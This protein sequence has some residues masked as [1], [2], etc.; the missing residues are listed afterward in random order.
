MLFRSSSLP[1]EDL[2]LFQVSFDTLFSLQA[3][4]LQL[5]IL[6]LLKGTKLRSQRE[7]YHFVFQGNAPYD[8]RASAWLKEEEMQRIHACAEAVEKF[9]NSAACRSVITAIL[10]LHW[11][12]SA[13][14]LFMDRTYQRCSK[15]EWSVLQQIHVWL[16]A[17]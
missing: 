4:E 15:N 3:S 5:G 8:V 16:K 14:A 11:Y 12:E 6:K 2:N 17:G 7:S 9:W 1:Y 10:K 13:F